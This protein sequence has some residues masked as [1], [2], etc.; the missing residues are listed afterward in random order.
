MTTGSAA[1]LGELHELLN[2]HFTLEEI[3][4]L[5]F[6]LNVDYESVAGE[7]KP[8]RI[9]ELLLAL[10]RNGRLPELITLAQKAHPLVTWNPLPD[11]FQLPV[12][13]ASSDTAVPA[14]Q[15]NYYGDVVQ[16]DKVGGDKY[17]IG[18][19]KDSQA[20]A[21]GAG[22][23]AEINH[24]T[25]IIVKLDTIEDL[26]AAPGEPPYKGLAYFTEK[27]ADI[28]YGRESLSQHISTRLSQQHFLALIGAS[29]SGKS[30]LLRAGI[31]P[32]LRDQNW[33]I[34]VIT[35]GIHPLNALTNSLGRDVDSLDFAPKLEKMM[36]QKTETLHLIGS[37]FASRSNAPR[38]LLAVDQFEEVFTQCRDE[39]ERRAFV[40][41]LLTA[42]NKQ[43]SVTILLGLRADFYDRCAYFEGLREL[44]S[45][46]QEFIGPMNQQ[47]LVRV[48]A[49]PARQGGWQFVEGLV[50]QILEDA[51]QEPGR[52]P[53]LSHALRETWERRRGVAMT[54]AGYRAAGGVEG[55]IAK[56]AE[57]VLGRFDEGE[58][59][60]AQ[61]I[62]LSLTELGEGAEDT[63]RI[64]S[65]TELAETNADKPLD[66][67]L[68]T[69]I[70]A[71]LIT[72]GDGQVEVAHEALIRRWPRLRGWL[73]D[74][75]E[76]LRFERQ[77]GDD[78]KE[79]E[80][81]GED[82]GALYRGARL[83][84][85]IE[86]VE[87]GK[88]EV[89]GGNGRF[90]DAS[91]EEA[92]R[93]AREK[94][95]QRQREL[96]Q[97]RKLAAEQKKRAEDAETASKRQRR[98]TQITFG[99]LSIAVIAAIFAAFFGIRSTKKEREAKANEI[100]MNKHANIALSRQLAAQANNNVDGDLGISLKLAAQAH[101][102]TETLEAKTVLYN[103]LIRS[104]Y[105]ILG[106]GGEVDDYEPEQFDVQ[107]T[108]DNRYLIVSCSNYPFL[109][110][111]PYS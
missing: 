103:I 35:P 26:P 90:L 109:I 4:T 42:A 2:Q 36:R 82:A 7:E 24:Y 8:S 22:A 92:E 25:E 30:S 69:L 38:L 49:E 84:Q 71:R 34:H 13:L 55:A 5:C 85:A 104:P 98:L 40:E 15:Y 63:R 64:A 108:N 70:N 14:N 62:F 88:I 110:S 32:R 6:N 28:Y 77:L 73:A 33:L 20:V 29:G 23:R 94:E 100:E 48:I 83:Q 43:G 41:N 50:E 44:V 99:V 45:Q 89:R 75:R 57:E 65:L 12:S 95:A 59:A 111:L 3:R 27:D 102:I 68:Q 86:L 79:W 96:A 52:L 60:V 9:R 37:K 80:E 56:T 1:Y 67:V 53:L 66:D 46:Q 31:I 81:L 97:Q 16:G 39:D 19:I 107:F 11:D 101:Q 87:K 54:L 21:I 91:R 51:G 93:E 105:R 76:R 17:D 61:S 72:T 47:E 10:G 58:T 18:E 74:N 106:W 78:A